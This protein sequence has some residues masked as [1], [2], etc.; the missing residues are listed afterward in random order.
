MSEPVANLGSAH[1]DDGAVQGWIVGKK[2]LA[3]H[4]PP[5][6]FVMPGAIARLA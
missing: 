2:K 4:E 3:A 6:R 1:G 5:K